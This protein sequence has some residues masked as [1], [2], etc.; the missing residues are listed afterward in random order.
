M[1]FKASWG[2]QL[3]CSKIKMPREIILIK[4]AVYTDEG[5]GVDLAKF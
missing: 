2:S 3:G 4:L 1:L 5:D